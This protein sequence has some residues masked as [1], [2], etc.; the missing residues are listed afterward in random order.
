M[1]GQGCMQGLG[2]ARARDYGLRGFLKKT[3]PIASWRGRWQLGA[4]TVEML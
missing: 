1:A 2:D 4:A 3:R